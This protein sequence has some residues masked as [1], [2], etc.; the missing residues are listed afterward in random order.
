M[1]KKQVTLIDATWI[2]APSSTKNKTGDGIGARL[3]CLA[4]RY[5]PKTSKNAQNQLK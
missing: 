3:V 4:V 1:D 2:S 5:E